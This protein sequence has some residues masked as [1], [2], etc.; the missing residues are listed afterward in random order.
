[1]EAATQAREQQEEAGLAH[2]QKCQDGAEAETMLND[3]TKKT[4]E[5]TEALEKHVKM[6]DHAGGIL[7]D[8][9]GRFLQNTSRPSK[10]KRRSTWTNSLPSYARLEPR[11]KNRAAQ[12]DKHMHPLE[13]TRSTRF[14]TFK[15]SVRVREMLGASLCHLRSAWQVS[16]RPKSGGSMTTRREWERGGHARSMSYFLRVP[17]QAAHSTQRR[18]DGTKH[19]K[20][21]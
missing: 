21:V 13:R 2:D 3:A 4:L 12:K 14:D 6:G 15:T 20:H 9:G 19:S 5:K 1:M 18:P 10:R 16:L 8:H 17:S 11:S 7:G